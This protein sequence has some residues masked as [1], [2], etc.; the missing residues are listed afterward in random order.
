MQ[1]PRWLDLGIRARSQSHIKPSINVTL[2]DVIIGEVP[3]LR[4]DDF[5]QRTCSS[6]QNPP[7]RARPPRPHAGCAARSHARALPSNGNHAC[8]TA[9]TD[10]AAKTP[11]SLPRRSPTR[12]SR[13]AQAA[14]RQSP[15]TGREMRRASREGA[16][17][18]AST[19][20]SPCRAVCRAV[21]CA[22]PYRTVPRRAAPQHARTRRHVRAD[23]HDPRRRPNDALA[24]SSARALFCRASEC[25][26]VQI[27]PRQRC[28]RC[29]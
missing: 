8:R 14:L 10:G 29:V 3:S 19:S 27:D 17:T 28:A 6:L 12:V 24:H 26:A 15:G 22:V 7:P 5:T 16:R 18:L 23:A 11:G 13:T 21:T 4:K 2:M 1:R 9:R 25:V 20:R